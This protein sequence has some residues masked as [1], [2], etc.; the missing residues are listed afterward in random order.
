MQCRVCAGEKFEVTKKYSNRKYSGTHNKLVMSLE[1]DVRQCHC[2]DCKTFFWVESKI[3]AE[4]V[5]NKSK[6]RAEPVPIE[7]KTLRSA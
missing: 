7:D 5:M 4:F 1:Y 3:V 6:L 2:V